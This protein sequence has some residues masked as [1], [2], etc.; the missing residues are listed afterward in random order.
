M[1]T[2]VLSLLAFLVV[3][4]VA[5]PAEATHFR[6]GHISYRQPDPS[7]P[8]K[9][10]FEVLVAWRSSYLPVDCSTL[11]FGDATSNPCTIGVTAGS[12]FDAS[13]AQYTLYRYVVR[14]TYA[15]SGTYTAFFTSCC[16]LS[17]LLNAADD[18]FRVEAVVDTTSGNT[19]GV[20]G[21]MPAIVQLQTGGVRTLFIPAMDPDGAPVSC[22]FS[23]PSQMGAS[24][25]INPPIA[26]GVSPTIQS[27]ANG[28]QLTWNLTAAAAGTAYAVSVRL[29]SVN[30]ASGTTSAT[31]VD[32]IIELVASPV[33]TVSGSPA[34]VT[35]RVNETYNRTFTGTGA[36]SLTASVLGSVG[37]GG[38]TGASPLNANIVFTPGPTDVGVRVSFVTFRTTS[39]I[40]SYGWVLLNAPAVSCGDGFYETAA[41]DGT[42]LAPTTTCPAGYAGTPLCNNDPANP[43]GDGSC[44]VDAV[45]DG[46]VD[47]DECNA[48]TA[49]CDANAACTN[50]PG[51][52][53]CACKPG[54]AGDGFGCTDVDEC[55][56]GTAG[57]D[58]NARCMNAPGSFSCA[59][60]PGWS[61]SGFACTDVDECATMTDTCDSNA[62]CTNASGTFVCECM[63]GF[64]GD[65]FSC[66]DLDECTDGTHACAAHATCTNTVGA[67]TCECQPGWM[68]SGFSCADVD[69]CAAGTDSCDPN[70]ICTNTVGAYTCAC[71]AGWVGDGQACS[72]IDECAA[73]NSCDPHAICT[74]T[75]GGFTCACEAGW[76][77]DG[78]TCGDVDECGD[79]RDDCPREVATCVNTTG[80]FRCECQPGY[81]GDGYACL[82]ISEEPAEGDGCGCASGESSSLAP[83]GLLALGLLRRRK[84]R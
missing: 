62:S 45:P 39:F 18:S 71:A 27:A 9:V 73:T 23:T 25:S 43:A 17:T 75:A 21:G 74:N 34:P 19:G 46:C 16:R 36:T 3:I 80:S 15:T 29:S 5:R 24:S 2:R 20:V 35:V 63:P 47:V 84:R 51:S 72:D 12:A 41:C 30:P 48:G 22:G 61:G 37:T 13:G 32:F 49:A 28:C 76:M 77:G 65:G 11:N 52:Y 42:S 59:C 8:R 83:F 26:A 44:T 69:E 66:A 68:G 1:C 67:Y 78:L 10:D 79:E 7:D 53:T 54:W 40:A 38:A 33:P 56:E 58:D 31:T 70:A 60:L 81:A 57:C 50:I 6:Y 82:E 4:G 55:T 64:A 14:H